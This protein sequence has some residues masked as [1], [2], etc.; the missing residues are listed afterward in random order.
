M[1]RYYKIKEW[2][3]SE[4]I[5]KHSKGL[6]YVYNGSGF[7]LYDYGPYGYSEVLVIKDAALDMLEISEE[8]FFLEMI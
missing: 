5:W 7:K 3:N 4:T 8:D 2:D 6:W 1:S